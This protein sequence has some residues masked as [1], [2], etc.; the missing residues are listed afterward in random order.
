MVTL[1]LLRVSVVSAQR[2][3]L[4]NKEDHCVQ[5]VMSKNFDV[6]DQFQIPLVKNIVCGCGVSKI[7]MNLYCG[8][9]VM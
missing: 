4:D 8:I 9:K 5:K 3:N 6:L 7:D 1:C 2:P